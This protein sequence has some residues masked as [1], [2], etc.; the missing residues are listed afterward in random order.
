MSGHSL[1][2]ETSGTGSPKRR[3]VL[4]A[5]ETLFLGQGYGAVSMDGVA[6]TAGV[7]KATLYA[8]FA[9]KDALFA[10]IVAERGLSHVLDEFG[11]PADDME[12]GAALRTIGDRVLRFMLRDRTLR[13]YRIAVAES[14]RFPELGRAFYENGPQRTSA[15]FQA[16]LA[17]RHALGSVDVTDAHVAAQH[18][19]AM[20]R[21]GLFL[22]ATLGAPPPPAEEEIRQTVITA[23]DAW[24]RAYGATPPPADY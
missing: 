2:P 13:L 10:T 18:F 1:V 24:L 4:D 6:R 14:E 23:V 21:G 19:M 22:R 8:Y 11:Y 3:Q 17:Q 20:L 5:A 9:S 12:I 7:S 16:W 15:R